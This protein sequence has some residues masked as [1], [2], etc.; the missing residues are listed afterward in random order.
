G[1]TGKPKG[2]MITHSSV[3]NFITELKQDI[4][5]RYDEK[6]R[7]ALM[8]NIVFDAS[9]QQVFP[10]LLNGH[11]LHIIDNESKPDINGLRGF[12][13]KNKIQL[14]DGTP[15]LLSLMIHALENKGARH[16]L[17][18]L[19]IGGEALSTELVNTFYKNP[20]N[21]RVIITNVYGPTESTVNCTYFDYP[22]NIDSPVV[23]IGKPLINIEIY[24]VS[25][26]NRLSPIAVPGE[27]CIA[28][29]GLAVGYLN[30]PLL[31]RQKFTTHPFKKSE[32]L[33]RT[34]DLGRWLPDGNIEFLGRIDNQ[35]KIR[36]F[37]IE[38]G[39]IEY[40]LASH[41]DI[42]EA[43]VITVEINGQKDLAAFIVSA[44]T[45][46]LKPGLPVPVSQFREYLGK[47][48]PDFMVPFHFVPLDQIPLTPSGKTDRNALSSLPIG[49]SSRRSALNNAYV[50]PGNKTQERLVRIWQEVLGVE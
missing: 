36:G 22:G 44:D 16:S 10:S 41:P 23:P 8:A 43:A 18:H 40:R 19:I 14:S 20:A 50:P 39:E 11:Q 38:L 4:Y 31:T 42:K 48:L 45:M 46:R 24:I 13:V 37:R 30:N 34:G 6:L 27:I 1:S 5:S 21:Q 3:V 49:V 15:T 12:L 7:V 17:K 47:S 29:A 26:D 2:V 28:G 25:L 32:R 35:V 9:V 33:Y